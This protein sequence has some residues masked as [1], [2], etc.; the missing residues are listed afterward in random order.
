[1]VRPC[2]DDIFRHFTVHYQPIVHLDTGRVVGFEALARIIADDGSFK[3]PGDFIEVIES[4]TECLEALLQITLESLQRVFVPLF[5]R[6][7][8]FYVSI[9]IPPPIFGSSRVARIFRDTGIL[10]HVNRLVIEITERQALTDLGREAILQGRQFGVEMALDDF[11]TGN[12]GIAQIAGVDL[13]VLKIDRSLVCPAL[14]NRSSARLL[15]AIVAFAGALRMR[16]IA[17]GVETW[18][19]AFFLHAAGVDAA[20]GWFWSRAVPG[21]EVHRILAEG[22]T[23]VTPEKSPS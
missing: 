7:P 1:M 11:G 13:D 3:S 20:Q 4:D 16:T 21:E 17:E 5:V 19:Q 15:R 18:E 14:T 23:P 2:P 6:H 22:F 12:S 10:P 9:N 8:N